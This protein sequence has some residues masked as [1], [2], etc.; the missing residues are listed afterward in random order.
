MC[1]GRLT[2]IVDRADADEAT[3]MR[4]ATDIPDS[5]PEAVAGV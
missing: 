4:L 3:V 5:G 1:R 2:G